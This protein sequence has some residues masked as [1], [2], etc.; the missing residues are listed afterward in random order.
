[1]NVNGDILCEARLAEQRRKISAVAFVGAPLQQP[2]RAAIC[3]TTIGELWTV[4]P[5]FETKLMEMTKQPSLHHS[6]IEQLI[7][8][9]TKTAMLS[10]D[11]AGLVGVWTTLGVHAPRLGPELFVKCAACD[12]K[13]VTWC[14]RC[15]Q[16]FCAQCSHERKGAACPG[17]R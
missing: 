16:M 6:K 5:V 13:P 8:N 4:T 2:R 10:L 3:G 12:Q 9:R 15:N 17:A 7:F 11:A 14:V 1:M